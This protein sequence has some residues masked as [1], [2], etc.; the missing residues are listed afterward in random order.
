MKE[1]EASGHTHR[2]EDEGTC[3]YHVY[4]FFCGRRPEYACKQQG[5]IICEKIKKHTK[6]CVLPVLFF[7]LLCFMPFSVSNVFISLIF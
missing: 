5:I 1:E 7:V 4:S 3:P 6:S 2:I